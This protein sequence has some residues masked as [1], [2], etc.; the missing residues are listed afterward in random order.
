M[1][2]KIKSGNYYIYKF[3]TAQQGIVQVS[4]EGKIFTKASLDKF[5]Q[6]YSGCGFGFDIDD[7]VIEEVK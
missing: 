4:V 5:I 6:K 1:K 7:C 3:T 2:Y